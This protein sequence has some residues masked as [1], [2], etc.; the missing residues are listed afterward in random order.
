MDARPL[1]MKFGGTSVGD[2]EAIVRL[3]RHVG[4][5]LEGNAGVLVVVSG[6]SRSPRPPRAGTR[7]S[8]RRV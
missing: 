1:V 3:V 2:P 4:T 6:C 5:A 8:W 7:S